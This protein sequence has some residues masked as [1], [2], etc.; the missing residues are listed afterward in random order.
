MVLAD[1]HFHFDALSQDEQDA[2]LG[3]SN[4]A[5]SG[6][7]DPA[8]TPAPE[9]MTGF[10]GL[11][12]GVW[13]A[14]TAAALDA[15]HA[16][17]PTHIPTHDRLFF[18]AGLHPAFIHHHVKADDAAAGLD[19][20]AQQLRQL[21]SSGRVAAIGETGFDRSRSLLAEASTRGFDR[22]ALE[23][24][25]KTAFE[26]CLAVAREYRLPLVFHSRDAW[27]LTEAAVTEALGH[28]K[29][30]GR[31]SPPPA[32]MIH[33]FPGP[34]QDVKSLCSRG[35]YLSFGGVITWPSCRRMRQALVECAPDRLLIETDAP[36]LPPVLPGG[37]KPGRTLPH[38][39]WPEILKAA[40]SFRREDPEVTSRLAH[41]N[42]RSFLGLAACAPHLVNGK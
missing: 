26:H 6:P 5:Q 35:V 21:A 18:A 38:E 22:Q 7:K 33:C 3:P 2:L 17:R 8:Q 34:P 27:A 40:A 15:W 20:A 37:H 36:D 14:Q 30:Q 13:P 42:L 4:P 25:Q 31:W 19:L 32:I 9:D 24:A 10:I 12:A 11:S 23:A 29:L 39:H 41:A 16:R 1:A 28:N